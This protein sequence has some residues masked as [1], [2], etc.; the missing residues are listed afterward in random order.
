MACSTMASPGGSGRL[1]CPSNSRICSAA[2]LPGSYFLRFTPACLPPLLLWLRGFAPQLP[3]ILRSCKNI[4]CSPLTLLLTTNCFQKK[5][6][7]DIICDTQKY[8]ATFL[9]SPR[10]ISWLR[11][12][13]RDG[14]DRQELPGSDE[15]PLDFSTGEDP[16]VFPNPLE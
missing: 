10:Y 5:N 9:L 14:A 11:R 4:I 7:Q 8:T 3:T 16:C 12:F 1:I 2:R 6:L 13:G 15:I